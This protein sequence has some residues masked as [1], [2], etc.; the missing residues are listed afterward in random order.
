MMDAKTFTPAEADAVL[1]LLHDFG[2]DDLASPATYAYL[3]NRLGNDQLF[4]RGLAYWHLSRLVPG[5]KQFGY[6]PRAP[7]QER[8]A[9]IMKWKELVPTGKL[10][11]ASRPEGK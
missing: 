4:V 7:K 2:D 3:I 9:A 10:P 11:L 1:Q 5:G 6:D 8:D